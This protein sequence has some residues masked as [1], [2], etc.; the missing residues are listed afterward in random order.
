MDESA[1]LFHAILYRHGAKTYRK[2]IIVGE[3]TESLSDKITRLQ[4]EIDTV[5][6]LEGITF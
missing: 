5:A 1:K 4:A 3:I 6:E 2:K